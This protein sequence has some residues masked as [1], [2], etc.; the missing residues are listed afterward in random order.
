MPSRSQEAQEEV[1]LHSYEIQRGLGRVE[2]KLDQII[3]GMTNHE[4]RDQSRFSEVHII[5]DK[6]DARQNRTE[7][8]IWLWSGAVALVAFVLSHIPYNLLIGK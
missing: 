3:L 4:D 1:T 7:R 8:K 2:G 6:L 5:L